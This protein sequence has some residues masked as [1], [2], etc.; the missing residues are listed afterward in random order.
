MRRVRAGD[1]R[2]PTHLR[3]DVGFARPALRSERALAGRRYPPFGRELDDDEGG[4]VEIQARETGARQDDGIDAEPLRALN[5]ALEL[6]GHKTDT[7]TSADLVVLSPGVPSEQPAVQAARARGIPIVGEI[8][9]AS[10]WLEGRVIAITGTKGKST[11]TALTGQ[12]LQSAGFHVTVGGNIGQPLSSQVD[13][14]TPETLHVVETSSFQLEQIDTFRPWI[15]V[16][17]NFSPDHLDRH[18]NLEAYGRAKARIF[19]NQREA[20]WAVVNADDA[21]SIELARSGRATRKDFSRHRDLER[22]VVVESGWIVERQSAGTERLVPLDAVHLLGPHLIDDVMAAAAVSRIA[23]AAPDAMTAAVDAFH[24]LEHAMELVA[25][26]DG[27]RFVNDSKATNVVSVLRSLESFERSD[28]GSHEENASKQ[29]SR[30]SVLIQSK[31][32]ML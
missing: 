26:M 6:G 14:A 4:Q 21:A 31:P 23:G 32:N 16:M 28:N 19:E 11:T 24:G 10:R 20:D 17:L 22:G 25:E 13:G 3:F 30:A 7:F 27:V 8:E 5:V 12:M 1:I 15:A 9:L 18:G 2:E 29:E